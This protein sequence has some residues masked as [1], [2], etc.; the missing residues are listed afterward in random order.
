MTIEIKSTLRDAPI[1]AVVYGAEG[2]GK[3]QPVSC[4]VLTPGGFVPIGQ[5]SAGDTIC[6]PHGST[7]TVVAVHQRGT[8]PVFRVTTSD[9][10]ETMCC[11]E[12]LWFTS[13]PAGRGEPRSG[14]M[15]TF[16]IASSLFQYR[17]KWPVAMHRIPITAPVAFRCGSLDLPLDPYLLGLLLGD[18]SMSST[19]RFCKP[20]EDLWDRIESMLPD[21]DS[22]S[23]HRSGDRGYA[24]I[25]GSERAERSKTWH[26]LNSMGLAGSDSYTK[27]IPDDYLVAS[28]AS[29]LALLRGLIDTDGS[30]RHGGRSV[31]FSTSSSR[32]ADGVVHL[33]RSLGGI[34]STTSRIPS[35]RHNGELKKGALS[36]RQSIW[37]QD[38]TVPVAS[39]KNLSRWKSGERAPTHRTIRSV[40]PAGED[41]CV[42]ITVSNADGL[43]ITDDF[44][45]TH[46]STLA[47]G[48][49]GA[50]FIA[51]E[52]GLDNIDA[53]A[54]SPP[55]SW[56]ELLAL[57][58]ALITDDRCGSLVI[59][60]LDWAEQMLW[61]H[62]V[63]TRPNEKGNKVKDIE[64][65]GYAKGYTAAQGEWR[66]L[67]AA[68]QRAGRAGKHVL[69]IA[70]AIRKGVKNPAGD[71]YE[72]WQIKL[73]EKAAGLIREW[74]HIVAFAELDIAT[75]TDKDSGNRSKGIF[76]GK[77]ILRTQPS[78]AYQTKSRLTLP[79]KIPLDWPA[80]EAAVKAG[81]PP[82]LGDL[83]RELDVMLS[84]AEESVRER[85]DRFLA[86]RGETAASLN[87]AITN[88]KQL[89]TKEETV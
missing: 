81:K 43:Y 41:E 71:D 50:I 82:S 8:L 14:T 60:S 56:P 75:F 51:T 3:A 11:A 21:G 62:L 53:R 20:E 30:V 66:P 64:G 69:L 83:R 44:I 27:F 6:D 46:N 88:V 74:V 39:Q 58:E 84:T 18:G 48:A 26:A 57:V 28:M 34:V 63:A 36:Y 19:V 80:F 54:V 47:A 55:E 24:N 40:E 16:E 35:Y 4:G 29:R 22:L 45:V 52:D 1:R 87:D 61:A 33:V 76:T 25:V 37:F 17:A 13:S 23:R 2:V 32:I 73:N 5:L 31:E 89:M 79:E 78:A 65:Y 10:G 42:C 67:L 9:G 59:D 70:H 86:A 49:P 38:E 15:Q 72:Q 85:C 7:Q 77:R 12:H 68:L